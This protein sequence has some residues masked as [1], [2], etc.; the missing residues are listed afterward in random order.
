MMEEKR[1]YLVYDHYIIPVGLH[2]YGYTDDIV[3]RKQGGYKRSALQQYIDEYGWDNINTT[4]VTEGLTQKEAEVLE[5]ELIKEGWKRGDCINERGSGGEWRDNPVE[6]RKQYYQDH[7]EEVKQYRKQYYQDHKDEFIQYYQDHKDEIKQYRKQYDQDHK[8]KKKQYD[9]QRNS[10]PAGKIYN[11]V[12]NYNRR[13]YILI[14]P[15]EAKEM[16]ILTGYIP[17][18]I[19]SDDLF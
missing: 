9:K 8:E 13:H 11:R 3:R 5:N 6:C 16:Y 19:K 18:F 2:Y 14:T 17:D 4:I 15:I 10:T 12:K 7:K 1:N